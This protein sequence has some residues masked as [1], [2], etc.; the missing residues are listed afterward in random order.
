M[1]RARGRESQ[2]QGS[3]C[4][5]WVVFAPISL[6]QACHVDGASSVTM[7]LTDFVNGRPYCSFLV[8][9]ISR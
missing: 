6:K 3:V 4:H 7:C 2:R 8:L 1:S 5:L 9:L